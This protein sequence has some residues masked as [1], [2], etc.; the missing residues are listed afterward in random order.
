LFTARNQLFEMVLGKKPWLEAFR[1]GFG[2][3]LGILGGVGAKLL[4]HFGMGVLVL[5]QIL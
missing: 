5:S 3:L 1:S 2:T 4:I